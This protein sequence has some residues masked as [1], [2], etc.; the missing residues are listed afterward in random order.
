MMRGKEQRQLPPLA[1][2]ERRCK[3]APPMSRSGG[4]KKRGGL[5][6]GLAGLRGYNHGL[7]LPALVQGDA[8]SPDHRRGQKKRGGLT[9]GLAGLRGIFTQQKINIK[10]THLD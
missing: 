7:R 5:T 1:Q 6:I 8:R 9:I 2:L 10:T 3:F 4:Q